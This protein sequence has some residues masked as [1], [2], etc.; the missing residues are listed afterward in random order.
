MEN[1]R[2]QEMVQVFLRPAK[3][4]IQIGIGYAQ[5]KCRSSTVSNQ[6][7]GLEP[8]AELAVATYF[9]SLTKRV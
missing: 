9:Y 6:E 8:I 2:L 7:F 1:F 4:P 3:V 5:P